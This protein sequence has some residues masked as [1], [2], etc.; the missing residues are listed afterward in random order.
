NDRDSLRFDMS[1]FMKRTRRIV[2]LAVFALCLGSARAQQTTP[3]TTGGRSPDVL[4]LQGGLLIDGTGGA[5]LQDPVI[6]LQAGKILRV[7]RKGQTAI[8][9]GAAI[10][11]TSGKT[12]IPG[13]VDSHVHLDD[14]E[15]PHF[16]YWGVTTIGDTGNVPSWI[17]AQ[18]QAVETGAVLG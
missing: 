2:L 17:H 18:K 13:L 7:G 16:L 3:P 6:V 11:D 14:S 5:T 12:I 9:A 8:P 15:L 4:V 10:I 1:H